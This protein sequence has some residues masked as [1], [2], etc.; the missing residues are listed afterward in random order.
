M[1]LPLTKLAMLSGYKQ[2]LN[3]LCWLRR[4]PLQCPADDRIPRNLSPMFK[5]ALKRVNL[6]QKIAPPGNR[7]RDARMGIL[8][9]TT[10]PAALCMNRGTKNKL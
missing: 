3:L 9:D 2:V 1:I 4:L 8:H 7:T 10:T 5:I 6:A